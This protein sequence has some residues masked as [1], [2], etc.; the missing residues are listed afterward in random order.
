MPGSNVY[1]RGILFT[2]IVP[3]AV[4]GWVPW[5]MTAGSPLGGGLWRLGWL[6]ILAGTFVYLVC[7]V[8]FLEARGTPAVFFTRALRH[9]WGE[10]PQRIVRIGLYRYSRNPMYLGVMT[11]VFGIAAV[12]ASRAATQYA[13]G[14]FLVF[15]LVVVFLE[16]PHL[17]ARDPEAFADYS[18]RV[19]R[20]VGRPTK[21]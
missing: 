5:S 13:L 2:L 14:L 3:C 20:W 12:H 11:A 7:L 19:P 4:G 6:L 18:T 8:S 10:E 1:L 21:H 16:E 17:K 15:H 9:V